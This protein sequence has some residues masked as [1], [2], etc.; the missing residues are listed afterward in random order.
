MYEE[1][2][3]LKSAYIVPRLHVLTQFEKGRIVFISVHVNSR[4]VLKF[5]FVIVCLLSFSLW[6]FSYQP[7]NRH[8]PI[9][10]CVPNNISLT[11]M[12]NRSFF[13]WL[14]LEISM[15]TLTA[16]DNFDSLTFFC[17]VYSLRN[18]Q[19]NIREKNIKDEREWYWSFEKS[20]FYCKKWN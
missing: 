3:V 14:M 8:S 17:F 9:E 7:H 15:A 11:L 16:V 5:V 13:L 4:W 20:A 12:K 6:C 10:Y 1:K 19:W 18:I 2:K